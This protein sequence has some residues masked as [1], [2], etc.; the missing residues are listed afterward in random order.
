[1]FDNNTQPD[2]QD[3]PI[4][5]EPEIKKGLWSIDK[6]EHDGQLKAGDV[7][8][9]QEEFLKHTEWTK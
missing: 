3:Q 6:F 1:M 8:R 2:P 7:D 9:D 4:Q 5:E